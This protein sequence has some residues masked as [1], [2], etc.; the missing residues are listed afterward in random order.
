MNVPKKGWIVLAI[1]MVLA[2]LGLILPAHF[3]AGTAWGEWGVDEIKQLAGYIPQ[4]LAHLTALWPA[5]LPDYAFRG[6]E[7]KGLGQL[8]LAYMM[9]AL[10]GMAVIVGVVWVIGKKLA[11]K[12]K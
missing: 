1:L 4:G 11:K 5:P 3:Q 9:S 10:L 7:A 2:P 8:S 12:D 6:W